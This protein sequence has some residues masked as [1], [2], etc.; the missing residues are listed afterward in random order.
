VR[1]VF[2]DTFY[3]AAVT[4]TGDAAHERA[5]GLSRAL[6]PDKIVTTD[7]VLCEYLA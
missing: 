2:A 3:W 6:K 4:S 5:I 7:E 1:A